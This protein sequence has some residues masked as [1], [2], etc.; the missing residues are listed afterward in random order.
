MT[1]VLLDHLCAPNVASH[2][3]SHVLALVRSETASTSTSSDV[4]SASLAKFC[5]RHVAHNGHDPR[6]ISHRA[7]RCGYDVADC[8]QQARA[9]HCNALTLRVLLSINSFERLMDG[10]FAFGTLGSILVIRLPS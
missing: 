3:L 5:S 4:A 8:S 10:G 2:A 7:A 1:G 6:A 9:G